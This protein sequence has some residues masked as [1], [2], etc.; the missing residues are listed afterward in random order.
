MLFLLAE[1]NP[2]SR[3]DGRPLAD[4]DEPAVHPR[5]VRAAEESR[6]HHWPSS[7]RRRGKAE[8]GMS[9]EQEVPAAVFGVALTGPERRPGPS[10]VGIATRDEPPPPDARVGV[11][12]VVR[13]LRGLDPGR[14]SRPS[15]RRRLG[16]QAKVL[17]D[18]D[19]TS[20]SVMSAMILRR[21]PQGHASTSAR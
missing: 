17:E 7:Q 16:G 13:P 2:G 21:P 5:A 8:E 15:D 12:V 19:M 4:G 20:G 11:R 9:A 3:G 18:R 1:G 14:S 6:T 10:R